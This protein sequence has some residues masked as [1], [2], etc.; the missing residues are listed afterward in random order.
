MAAHP[1]IRAMAINFF[2]LFTTLV[3]SLALSATQ[4]LADKEVQVLV[5]TDRVFNRME[6]QLFHAFRSAAAK[7]RTSEKID[8]IFTVFNPDS[9]QS[10]VEPDLKKTTAM[11]RQ[12]LTL[13]MGIVADLRGSLKPRQS[14]FQ[15]V[16]DYADK[17]P[18]SSLNRLRRTI[19]EVMTN[20]G[21]LIVEPTWETVV[22]PIFYDPRVFEVEV[23]Y[24]KSE[25]IKDTLLG[26]F[27]I[28]AALDQG[29]PVFGSCHG[30]QLG[31]LLAGGGLTRLFDYTEEEPSGAY[32]TRR[33]P[34]SGKTEIWWIDRMLNSCDPLRQQESGPILY[35]VPEPFAR[36]GSGKYFLKDFSHTLAMT[37]PD[38]ARGESAVPS[39]FEH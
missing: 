35:P 16:L 29:K 23:G 11:V 30:A 20:Y 2:V 12:D 39:P 18:A 38:P 15:T 19:N 36:E 31:W 21:F 8:F 24:A 9:P 6:P 26:L 32:F 4:A 25:D 28:Q 14:L 1:P 7:A 13:A 10:L 5:I 3:F 37:T 34:Q 22:H 17:H 33:N 27:F